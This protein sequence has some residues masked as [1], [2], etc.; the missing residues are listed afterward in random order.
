MEDVQLTM[1]ITAL[2]M[3]GL[4]NS[5]SDNI[6]Q[7]NKTMQAYLRVI[8]SLVPDHHNKANITVKKVTQSFWFPSTYKSYVYT[9]LQS[10][11]CVVALCLKRSMYNTK[12]KH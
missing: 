10:I 4:N 9:I 1:P 8:A 2:N 5:K 12:K 7:N 11:K 3:K 6:K